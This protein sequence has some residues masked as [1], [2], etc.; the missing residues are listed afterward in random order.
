MTDNTNYFVWQMLVNTISVANSRCTIKSTHKIIQGI[1][2]N[3]NQGEKTNPFFKCK[4]EQM[5]FL[6]NTLSYLDDKNKKPLQKG[7][8]ELCDMCQEYIKE[9]NIE[10]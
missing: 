4:I 3:I 5:L 9:Q 6:M 7:I 10:M 8:R 1:V 2:D